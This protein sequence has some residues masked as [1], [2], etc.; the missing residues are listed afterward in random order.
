MFSLDNFWWQSC[1]AVRRRS[2]RA[3]SYPHKACDGTSLKLRINP[4]WMR[5]GMRT[6]C[7]GGH[8]RYQLSL[9]EASAG[10]MQEATTQGKPGIAEQAPSVAQTARVPPGAMPP[11]QTRRPEPP[12]RSSPGTKTK[13]TPARTICRAPKADHEARCRRF[14]RVRSS[15]MRHTGE[16]GYQAAIPAL[17]HQGAI[18]WTEANES[19]LIAA[20]LTGD[21]SREQAGQR[22]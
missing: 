11:L 12:P 1:V 13:L 4:V 5:V 3:T 20:P 7:C 6:L 18:P 22:N 9:R 16:V 17:K 10:S 2:R 21:A 14:P 19:Y 8:G 15:E